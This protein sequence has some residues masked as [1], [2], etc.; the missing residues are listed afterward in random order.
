MISF[1]EWRKERE[2]SFQTIGALVFFL[3]G[4]PITIL[5][6]VI[7]YIKEYFPQG[8][9]HLTIIFF[10]EIAIAY[11]W[12]Y[13]RAIFP[14]CNIKKGNIVIAIITENGKQKTRIT[15]D[16]QKEI[17]RQLR[18]HNLDVNYTVTVLHNHL[19]RVTQNKINLYIQSLKAKI[20]DSEDIISFDKLRKKLNAKFIIY[21]D[22][23]KRNPTNSTYCLSVDAMICHSPTSINGSNNLHLEFKELWKKE[24][25]FLEEHV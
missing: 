5:S 3:I 17:E 14:R 15:Q 2:F 11:Y 12:Y 9:I 1:N 24:I 13:N 8:W 25:T 16:F 22:L 7:P 20:T 6:L 19:S 10:V 4:A 18:N 21:G 23:I